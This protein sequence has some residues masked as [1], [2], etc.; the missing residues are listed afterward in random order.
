[1]PFYVPLE[2]GCALQQSF[3]NL[4]P[5]VILSLKHPFKLMIYNDNYSE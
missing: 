4:S 2:N 3:M 1:M 5:K